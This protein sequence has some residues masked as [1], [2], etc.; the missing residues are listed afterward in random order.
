M[1]S[2][3]DFLASTSWN[4]NSIT[5]GMRPISSRLSPMVQPLPIVNVFPAP[6]YPYASIVALKPTKHPR[7]RFFTHASKTSSQRESRPKH[8][9]KLKD[10]SLPI[11]T[12]FSSSLTLIHIADRSYI[13]L[14]ISGRILTATLTEQAFASVVSAK[15]PSG[16][17]YV[18]TSSSACSWFYPPSFATFISVSI[19]KNI[20][21]QLSYRENVLS[22]HEIFS[23]LQ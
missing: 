22:F 20:S 4:T 16:F 5:L 15:N 9:S 6:V 23:N 10:L 14:P 17:G 11:T 19:S 2:A 3:L 7:T 1:H 21:H 12:W 18:P 13:S 8:L